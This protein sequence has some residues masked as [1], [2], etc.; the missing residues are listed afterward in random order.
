MLKLK[1]GFTQFDNLNVNLTHAPLA[2]IPRTA[3]KP[4]SGKLGFLVSVFPVYRAL[5]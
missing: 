4:T 3:T 2:D 1:T 5:Q